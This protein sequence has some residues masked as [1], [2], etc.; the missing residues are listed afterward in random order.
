MRRQSPGRV[1]LPLETKARPVSK[2]RG[3]AISRSVSGMLEGKIHEKQCQRN[4]T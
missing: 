4:C 2:T 3:T 1:V